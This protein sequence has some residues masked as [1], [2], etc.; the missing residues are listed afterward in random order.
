MS[1]LIRAGLVVAGVAIIAVAVAV[2]WRMLAAL[3][4]VLFL[5]G[6]A[7]PDRWGHYRGGDW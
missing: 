6:V 4:L 7:G 1:G 2:G 5:A 3:G